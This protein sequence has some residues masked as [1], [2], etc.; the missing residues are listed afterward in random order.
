MFGD[1]NQN[2]Q[3][4]SAA[5]A[6]P[7]TADDHAVIGTPFTMDSSPPQDTTAA[8]AEPTS[9]PVPDISTAAPDEPAAPAADEPSP[10]A[11]PSDPEPVA[12]DSG[13][14][15]DDLINIKQQALQQLQPLVSHLEQTPEEKF[16]TTMM[17]LQA[18]DD[19]SLVKTAYDTAQQIK[20][21]KQRAQALLDIINEIN[22][23]T[24]Q[25]EN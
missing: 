2:D 12:P 11:A 5:P 9:A 7:P 8:P 6:N 25:K 1:N 14:T 13:G 23:F 19:Q 10:S 16:K 22:Y 15:S 20:D 24:N 21:E 17:M 3:A 18:S 4:Q